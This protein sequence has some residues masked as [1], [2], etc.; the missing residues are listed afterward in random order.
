MAARNDAFCSSKVVLVIQQL[1]EIFLIIRIKRPVLGIACAGLLSIYGCGGGGGDVGGGG[2][3]V[4]GPSAVMIQGTVATGAAFLDAVVTVRDRTGAIAGTSSPVGTDGVFNVTLAD[5][6]NSPYVLVA[7]RT[8]A[9]GEVQTMVS[10]AES[11]SATTANITPIT[12]L[13]AS[14][15]S[16]TGD[17]LKLVSEFVAGTATITPAAV[18]A[19][20]AEINKILT[21]LLVAT[22]TTGADPLKSAFSTN[23][24]GYDRLL[25]SLK[26]TITPSNASSTN[27]EIAVKQKLLE[28][29]QPTVIKFVSS[30]TSLPSLPPI[31]RANLVTS[32]TSVLIADLLKSFNACYALPLASRVNTA[33]TGVAADIKATTCKNLFFGNNPANF[34]SDGDVVGSDKLFSGM[35]TT[36]GSGTIFSQGSYEAT[37]DNGDLVI[38][39]KSQ[40]ASGNGGFD[41]FV[42][43]NDT[44]GKLKLIGNQYQYAGSV[45]AYHQF[46]Q[47]ITLNQSAYNYYSTGYNMSFPDVKGGRG[48]ASSIFDRVVV[49][50]PNGASVTLKPSAGKSHLNLVKSS[51]VT[52]TNYLRLRS[53]FADIATVGDI[54]T[55]DSN[56]VF[57][58]IHFTDQ[59][60]AAIASQSVWTF[61][62]YL[63]ANT[64]PNGAANATQYFKTRA[65]ALT[66]E[67][68]KRQ[69]LPQL[70]P[71]LISAIQ[72]KTSVYP[73]HAPLP[74]DGPLS[75]LDF[76]VP[77]GVLPVSR[78]KLFGRHNLATDGA[79]FDESVEIGLTAR[80]GSI[81]CT[82]VRSAHCGVAGAFA[83]ST[84]ATGLHL[85]SLDAAGREFVNFYAMYQLIKP[86]SP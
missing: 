35:F 47:F 14:R 62:Y 36:S 78:I 18:V 38:A 41:T 58:N 1:E 2:G 55:M 24:S 67:E 70:S 84:Y 6:T 16:P 4:A 44:D 65:R 22:D 42:V 34:R 40:D 82:S 7:Q 11:A 32:G 23:G 64:A 73:G 27:I 86:S 68:L 77:S 54:P 59:D 28:G 26:I 71:T 20:V 31:D 25:D 57:S 45:A 15:L 53:V 21:P 10:V 5:G 12:N 3:S 60:V 37:Q 49:T 76:S 43:R 39:Y 8:T 29:V 51:V 50:T 52:G 83:A 75:G 69:G 66:I 9:A 33:G 48:V 17:P 46:R 63:A 79:I 74:T 19:S 61:S 72:A 80:T 13:I 85:Y 56:L 30:A 81:A